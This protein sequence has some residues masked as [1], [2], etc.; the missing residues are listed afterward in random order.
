MGR[1]Q[2]QGQDGRGT[3]NQSYENRENGKGQARIAAILLSDEK[4]DKGEEEGDGSDAK[5]IRRP[6]WK[7]FFCKVESKKASGQHQDFP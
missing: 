3:R 5:R 2:S 1:L 7:A 6:I 4:A